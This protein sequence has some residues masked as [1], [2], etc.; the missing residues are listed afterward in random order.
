MGEAIAVKPAPRML[1]DGGHANG[2]RVRPTCEKLPLLN[3]VARRGLPNLIEATVIPAIMFFVVV[4]TINAPIAMAAERC[5][6]T[7]RSCV[8]SSAPYP[9]RRSSCSQR[10]A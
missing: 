4:K 10:L 5:G 3:A 7:S 2:P 1:V 8:A 6:H 9:S